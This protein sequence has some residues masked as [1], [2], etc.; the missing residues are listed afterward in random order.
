[1][2]ELDVIGAS[3]A[4]WHWIASAG[5]V[6]IRLSHPNFLEDTHCITFLFLA[7]THCLNFL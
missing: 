4:A 3:M 1:M 2:M 6:A 5:P 7:K